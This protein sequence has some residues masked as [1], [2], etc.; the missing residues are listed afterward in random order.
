MSDASKDKLPVTISP[1]ATS[2]TVESSSA[3]TSTTAT[4]NGNRTTLVSDSLPDMESKEKQKRAST[5]SLGVGDATS[6]LKWFNPKAWTDMTA[7]KKSTEEWYGSHPE[8]AEEATAEQAGVK[9]DDHHAKSLLYNY[10]DPYV[11]IKL[12]PYGV[13][14]RTK[15]I[16][17]GGSNVIFTRADHNVLTFVYPPK[18]PQKG[19]AAT[20]RFMIAVYDQDAFSTDDLVGKS[21][22]HVQEVL[23]LAGQGITPKKFELKNKKGDYAGYVYGTVE[24]TRNESSSSVASHTI[25]FT[26][27]E[28]IDMQDVERDETPLEVN[29]RDLR[30]LIIALGIFLVFIILSAILYGVIQDLT[31]I[32]SIYFSIVTI[33]TVGY[34]DISPDTPSTRI[35][36]MIY[37][38]CG[39]GLAG[40]C[41]GE[42]S[43]F[44]LNKQAEAF[45]K[46]IHKAESAVGHERTDQ[47]EGEEGLGDRLRVTAN[48]T[49]NAEMMQARIAENMPRISSYVWQALKAIVIFIIYILIFST[50]LLIW[51]DWD[52]L[53]AIYF[54][55]VTCTTVGYGDFSPT[56]DGSKLYTVF[57]IIFGVVITANA[58]GSIADAWLGYKQA[59]LEKQVLF[60]ELSPEYIKSLDVDGD[61]HITEYEFT[62]RL[63]LKLGRCSENDLWL[64]RNQFRQLDETGDGVLDMDDIER[65]VKTFR[66][67]LNARLS[68]VH[69]QFGSNRTLN[70]NDD[71]V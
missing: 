4:G 25:T 18:D 47:D 60:A 58:L 64:I 49:Q 13:S 65:K 56:T 12:K 59:K 10:M 63:L 23:E 36:T 33:T 8:L 61:G 22:L 2:P 54:G 66:T 71:N 45:K 34:G 69:V 20:D 52:Y 40:L 1:A 67:N 21:H 70:A 3:R 6:D 39:I 5:V 16:S 24:V 46:A 9:M 30:F 14:H 15:H 50:F 37:I 7:T 29:V 44:L 32:D 19:N 41:L 42:L 35:I 51:E 31:V 11:Y 62:I 57:F 48:S 55:V 43:E 38:F 27:L 28:G 17:N 68:G 53:D 26:I